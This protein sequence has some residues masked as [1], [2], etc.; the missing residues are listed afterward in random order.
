M[1]ITLHWWM[2]P[3][4]FVILAFILPPLFSTPSSGPVS[5]DILPGLIFLALTIAAIG[6]VIG[7][8]L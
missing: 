2:L 4:L 8:Y 5:L 7:H 3:L 1:T 6:I